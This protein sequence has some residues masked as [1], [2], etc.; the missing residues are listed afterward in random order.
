MRCSRLS[1]TLLVCAILS[2]VLAS[3]QTGSIAGS[4][5]DS[6]GAA[7]PGAQVRLDSSNTVFVSDGQGQFMMTSVRPGEHTLI[8]SYVGFS[9]TTA[10]V[11]VSAG[12]VTEANI[13]MNVA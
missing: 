10:Q 6:A 7:L 13:A 2:A 1:S 12:Q 9:A 3:A 8:V 5:K 11:A 4:V